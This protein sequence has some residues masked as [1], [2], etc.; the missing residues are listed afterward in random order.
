[1]ILDCAFVKRL[2]HQKQFNGDYDY[3][4]RGWLTNKAYADTELLNDG[5]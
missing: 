3:A 4:Q 2:W 1:M 5:D